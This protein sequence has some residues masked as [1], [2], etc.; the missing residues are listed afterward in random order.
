M[1]ITKAQSQ[2]IKGGAVLLMI[3]HH[4]FYY[5]SK[6]YAVLIPGI[7]CEHALG[8]FGKICVPMFLIVSGYGLSAKGNLSYGSMIRKIYAFLKIYWFYY[9]PFVI[10]GIL[11]A[12][13]CPWLGIDSTVY[14]LNIFNFVTDALGITSVYNGAWWFV[15]CYFVC[16]L[17]FPSLYKSVQKFPVLTISSGFALYIASRYVLPTDNSDPISNVIRWNCSFSMGIAMYVFR[18]NLVSFIQRCRYF[19]VL[20]FAAVIVLAFAKNTGVMLGAPFLVYLVTKLNPDGFADKGLNFFGRFSTPIWL[21]HTFF[22]NYYFHK[23][24]FFFTNPILIYVEAVVVSLL[25]SMMLEK[26]RA[27]LLHKRPAVSLAK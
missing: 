23:I 27:L 21:I 20:A 15:G 19:S 16:V 6:E 18:Q 17:L 1:N 8:I 2:S 14:R 9:F 10:G 26:I 11:L 5:P 25:A 12:K 13:Y 22:I 3:V 24:A 7:P 4:L